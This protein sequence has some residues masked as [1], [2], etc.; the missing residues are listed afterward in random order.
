MLKFLD[1]SKAK[2]NKWLI[3]NNKGKN[4]RL[5]C[6]RKLSVW[7]ICK[8]NYKRSNSNLNNLQPSFQINR[9][10]L[11]ISFKRRIRKLR[12]YAKPL[13]NYA[14]HLMKLFLRQITLWQKYQKEYLYKLNLTYR[15]QINFNHQQFKR[16]IM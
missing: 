8:F 4:R 15:I 14:R 11:L 13:T 5:N 12:I 2:I 7:K 1:I 3:W 9:R 10:L 6:Q 16:I